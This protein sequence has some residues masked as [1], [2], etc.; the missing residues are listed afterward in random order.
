[1]RNAYGAPP[2]IDREQLRNLWRDRLEAAWRQV[3][4]D[5]AD[6][7]PGSTTSAVRIVTAAIQL[8]GLAEP[9]KVSVEVDQS[10]DLLLKGLTDDGYL[11]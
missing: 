11:R 9:Q 5:M 2:V 10:F 7:V 4:A 8:D 6:R 3:C 1:M